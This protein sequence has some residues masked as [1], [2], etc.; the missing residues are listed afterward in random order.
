M[1]FLIIA[2]LGF[3]LAASPAL[4]QV[5]PAPPPGQAQSIP[6]PFGSIGCP[7]HLRCDTVESSI[8][9]SNANTCVARYFSLNNPDGFFDDSGLDSNNCLKPTL[10]AVQKGTAS[11]L[12]PHCCLVQ[13]PD[14]NMCT[15][16]CQLIPVK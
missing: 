3:A 16:N 1:R 12:Q 6:H 11:Q 14:D 2:V 4:A 15:F 9:L 8:L 7:Q 13:L 10:N 5:A